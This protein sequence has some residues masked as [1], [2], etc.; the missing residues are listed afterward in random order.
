MEA[1][2]KVWRPG[3]VLLPGTTALFML[4][5]LRLLGLIP[6]LLSSLVSGS[7]IWWPIFS[8]DNWRERLCCLVSPFLVVLWLVKRCATVVKKQPCGEHLV[9]IQS[10]FHWP[11]YL[12]F[13]CP[14]G[15][16]VGLPVMFLEVA[17]FHT[18]RTLSGKVLDSF[19]LYSFD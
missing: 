4:V 18:P 9:A 19:S 5:F 13:F 1:I 12:H 3:W 11:D 8:C 14:G 2:L 15:T 6:W 10:G 17:V 7:Q 16:A